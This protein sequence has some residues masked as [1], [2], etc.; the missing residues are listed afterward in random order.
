M[1]KLFLKGTLLAV[2]FASLVGFVLPMLFSAKSTEA[3]LLAGLII[4]A[5]VHYV[6]YTL[7]KLYDKSNSTKDNA[8]KH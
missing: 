6:V 8:E 3:V 7:I 5:M 2:I 4:V 1:Y